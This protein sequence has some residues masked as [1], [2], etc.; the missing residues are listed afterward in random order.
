MAAKKLGLLS[1]GWQDRCGSGSQKPLTFSR[2]V[3]LEARKD[4]DEDL[5]ENVWLLG[6]QAPIE[7]EESGQTI[8]KA[9][10]VDDD[11]GVRA[12]VF[13]SRRC[14]PETMIPRTLE[15]LS[16]GMCGLFRPW[17]LSFAVL[18]SASKS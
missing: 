18:D 9:P 6:L 13:S 1:S 12:F 2:R 11:E 16:K 5:E 17:L 14:R 8:P 7:K 4:S 15:R 3:I 10:E